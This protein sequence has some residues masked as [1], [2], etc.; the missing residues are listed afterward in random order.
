M[1]GEGVYCRFEVS[2]LRFRL[3]CQW[4]WQNGLFWVCLDG[5]KL[6]VKPKCSNLSILSGFEHFRALYVVIL[7]VFVNNSLIL[8]I[9]AWF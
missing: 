6:R 1:F 3:F 4:F 9:L 5:F 2:Y 7:V 8:I